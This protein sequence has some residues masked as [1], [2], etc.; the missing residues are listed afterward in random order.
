MI[1]KLAGYVMHFHRLNKQFQFLNSSVLAI[2]KTSVWNDVVNSTTVDKTG[3]KD[4]PLKTA[5]HEIV[6]V[7]VCLATKGDGS[8][9]N[10][11]VVFSQAKRESK[12]LHEEYKCQCSVGSSTNGQ[13]NEE[14]TLQWIKKIVGKFASNKRLLAQD[15]H[16]AHIIEDVKIHFKETNTE[17]VIVPV[18]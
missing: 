8:K 7:S 13:M 15:S 12:C 3:S 4:V 16:E 6:K 1:D 5:G 17:S 2:D 18:R 14:L 9:L 11:F 10:S